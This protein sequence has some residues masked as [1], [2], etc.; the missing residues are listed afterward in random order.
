MPPILWGL[1]AVAGLVLAGLCVATCYAILRART[2]VRIAKW[3]VAHIAAAVV[4]AAT[5]WLVV[6]LAPI[7]ISVNIH[8]VPALIGWVALTLLAFGVLVLLPLAALLAAG[9]W[10]AVRRR[11]ATAMP[12]NDEQGV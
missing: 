7:N 12:P 5:P 11:G 2:R 3:S 6:R 10:L 1:A 4:I 9:V 8:T